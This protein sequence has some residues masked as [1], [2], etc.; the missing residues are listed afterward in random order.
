MRSFINLLARS[1]VPQEKIKRIKKKISFL[2]NNSILYPDPSPI[3]V[4][5]QKLTLREI[6]HTKWKDFKSI[7]DYI[8]WKNNYLTYLKNRFSVEEL[9]AQDEKSIKQMEYQS[10]MMFHYHVINKQPVC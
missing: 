3:E 10:R 6:L 2:K 1:N 7:D 8:L 5:G 9:I 4:F